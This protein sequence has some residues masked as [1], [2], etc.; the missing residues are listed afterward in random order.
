MTS[1]S[2]SNLNY[3]MLLTAVCLFFFIFVLEEVV[4]NFVLEEVVNKYLS[5]T[6]T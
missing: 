5:Y 2:P 3:S 4:N 1:K 6:C